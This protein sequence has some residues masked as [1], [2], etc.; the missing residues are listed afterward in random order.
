MN[1]SSGLDAAEM[2]I[3]RAVFEKAEEE[4]VGCFLDEDAEKEI[5]EFRW[6]LNMEL[7]AYMAVSAAGIKNI[8]ETVFQRT[9]LTDY[10]LNLQSKFV[11]RWA[12]DDAAMQRL[13]ENLAR[14]CS[15]HTHSS[16][17]FKEDFV[18]MPKLY[19]Q[20]FTAKEDIV[21][22]LNHNPWLTMVLLSCLYPNVK[23]PAMKKQGKK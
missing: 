10:I 5:A 7:K 9:A 3:V 6:F 19:A 18:A 13:N 20:Q 15:V 16:S 22:L 1:N 23:L 17:Q 12:F 2:E 21:T 14:S 4:A 11:A 8:S